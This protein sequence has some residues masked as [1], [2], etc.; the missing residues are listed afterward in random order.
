MA[1]RLPRRLVESKT[2]GSGDIELAKVVLG[3]GLERGRFRF[4]SAVAGTLKF[5]Y[6]KLDGGEYEDNPADVAVL[7]NDETVIELATLW[8]EYAIKVIFNSV[9]GVVNFL[10]W[11][12]VITS[13]GAA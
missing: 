3:A 2:V 1:T 5:R 10:D 8:G 13:W 12:A 7:A 9:G 11:S 4:K 6:L